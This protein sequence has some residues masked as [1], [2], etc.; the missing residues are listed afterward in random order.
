[1][2]DDAVPGLEWTVQPGDRSTV[3]HLSGEIDLG[4]QEELDQAVRAGLDTS[5]PVVILDL[6]KVTFLGSTGLRVLVAAHTE[7]EG[8]GR[9]VRIVDGVEI[10]HRIMEVTGLERLLALYPTV[11]QAQSA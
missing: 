3:V 9:V 2:I 1:V 6:G 5:A 7:A 4:T 11:E 8:T 10:V